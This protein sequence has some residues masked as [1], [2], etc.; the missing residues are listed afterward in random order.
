MHTS[1]QGITNLKFDRRYIY[2]YIYIYF[3]L[4]IQIIQEKLEDS[5]PE[6]ETLDIENLKNILKTINESIYYL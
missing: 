1:I 4:K 6:S 5:D 3:F 2:I